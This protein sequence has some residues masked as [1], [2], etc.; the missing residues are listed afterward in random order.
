MWQHISQAGWLNR[1]RIAAYSAILL[2]FELMAFGFIV[3][4]THGWLVPLAHP[5]TTDFVSF[6]A[7]GKLATAGTPGLAY[8]HAAHLAMEERIAGHG[9]DYAFFFYPP[10]FL[11]ICVLLARL[12]YLT[13]FVAFETAT[14][15][16]FLAVI[17]R[18]LPGERALVPALAFPAVFIN[19][20]VGQNGFLTAGLIGFGTLLVDR[21][22]WLAGVLFGALAY[23][24]QFAILIPLALAA[25][26][27]WRAFTAAAATAILLVLLSAGVFGPGCWRD[28]L[29]AF[30]GAHAVYESG[31]VDF[32]A[33]VSAFGTLRLWGADARLAYATQVFVSGMAACFTGFVWRRRLSLPVRAATLAAAT[34]AAVPL[35]LFYDCLVGGVAIAWLWRAALKRGWMA[36][37]RLALASAYGAP[38]L[39]RGLGRAFH[40][41]LG[42]FMVLALLA[43]CAARAW[44]EISHARPSRDAVVTEFFPHP[45][46]A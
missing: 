9:I 1:R 13:A 35:A 15:A 3:A 25:G 26:G 45:E 7:A 27:N 34:L 30:S 8:V 4:G 37:E 31:K 20:G 41:P 39:C 23:K 24:P 38:L 29:V 22:P 10:V 2:C 21:R 46:K 12:P 33:F 11:L 19:Y 44:Q 18:I 14:L 28:F 32:A 36:Y 42:L 16:G 17:R 43:L 6:Y 40:L 5:V